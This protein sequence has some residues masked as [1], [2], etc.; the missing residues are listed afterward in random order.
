MVVMSGSVTYNLPASSPSLP[1]SYHDQLHASFFRLM[2]QVM[3]QLHLAPHFVFPIPL[4]LQY[5]SYNPSCRMIFLCSRACAH[6]LGMWVRTNLASRYARQHSPVFLEYSFDS[7]ATNLTYYHSARL[8]TLSPER[9]I[10]EQNDAQFHSTRRGSLAL[11]NFLLGQFANRWSADTYTEMLLPERS[12]FS[13]RATR[14]ERPSGRSILLGVTCPIRRSC[15]AV[16]STT[17]DSMDFLKQMINTTKT[18]AHITGP[19]PRSWS[20]ISRTKPIEAETPELG[21]ATRRP[22]ASDNPSEYSGGAQKSPQVRRNLYCIF[23]CVSIQVGERAGTA[24]RRGEDVPCTGRSCASSRWGIQATC[25]RTRPGP[26]R[27][28]SLP[29]ASRS[30]TSRRVLG[31]REG[32]AAAASSRGAHGGVGRCGGLG[33]EDGVPRLASVVAAVAAVRGAHAA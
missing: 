25:I 17:F 29:P 16:G 28:G 13:T 7:C 26:T 1:T 3:D 21:T 15:R 6:L 18:Q 33:Q 2:M 8:R 24:E 11:V 23:S 9:A 19:G 27:R 5:Y 10:L 31:S 20:P 22:C 12:G 4:L 14:V 30:Q 32:R